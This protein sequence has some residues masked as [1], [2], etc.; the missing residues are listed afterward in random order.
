MPGS[1]GSSCFDII[2]CGAGP[3]GTSA[4][5]TLK[6]SGYSVCL[7][8]K[9]V[10]PRDKICGDALS[11]K[12][13][14]VARYIDEN[15]LE[16]FYDFSPK[17]GS[18]GIRFLSPS[19]IRLDIPFK[20]DLESLAHAPGF[21]SRRIDFDHFLV[22][23]A[24][25][26]DHVT[27]KPGVT[28]SNIQIRE[29]EVSLLANGEE[30]QGKVLIGADG[31]HSIVA[32]TTGLRNVHKKHHS[33][34]VRAY[35]TG[36]SGFHTHNFIELHFLKDLLPGYF[37]I[38]P[39]LNGSANVG[40]GMLSSDL[41]KHPGLNFRNKMEEVMFSHPEIAPRFEGA[42]LE[43]KISGFGLPLGSR[44]LPISSDRVI[45]TGD[46]ASLIDPFSGEGIGNA[47]I[48]GRMAAQTIM[49]LLPDDKMEAAS[50][51]KYDQR[52]YKKIGQE[53]NIS[54]MMQRLVNYPWLFDFVARKG[55]SNP[56]LK[57]LMT[58]MFESVDLRS[59]LT[60]ASF[61]WKLLFGAKSSAQSAGME[62]SAKQI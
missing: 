29:H 28:V 1:L 16:G 14:S 17:I 19:G 56:S 30:I 34:G 20:K 13:V 31:A 38:F 50:L 58:M 59:E 55:N 39:L 37:W 26:C 27:W 10:F 22:E 8:D 53:L 54:R 41:A 23:R 48:S 61:Y 3:A 9:A 49:E 33:A 42:T 47:M 62:K 6:E 4:A 36:V 32:R 52:L 21:V 51:K 43:G 12:V 2:I 15:L 45:L 5:L 18:Y 24:I 35:V 7:L 46:A 40:L 25:A 57:L 60:R 44:R 11:G